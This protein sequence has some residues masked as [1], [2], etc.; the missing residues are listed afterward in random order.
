MTGPIKPRPP[1]A[2]SRANWRKD[3]ARRHGC[4]RGERSPKDVPKVGGI[5]QFMHLKN[6]QPHRQRLSANKSNRRADK[7]IVGINAMRRV[8][9][10]TEPISVVTKNPFCSSRAAKRYWKRVEIKKGIRP[11]PR[12]CIAG[13]AG[14]NLA[15]SARV[16]SC[17]DQAIKN[18]ANGI[19][20]RQRTSSSAGKRHQSVKAKNAPC[21]NRVDKAAGKESAGWCGATS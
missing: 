4:S 16:K 17:L 11:R 9:R 8:M 3:R 1:V 21:A 15:P 19:P 14:K 7:V 13:R 18:A 12:S 6:P 2:R 20:R 5:A 10:R